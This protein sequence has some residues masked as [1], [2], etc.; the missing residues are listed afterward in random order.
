MAKHWTT[1]Q[2]IT[3]LR[4]YTYGFSI[5]MIAAYLGTTI[6]AVNSKLHR[7]RKQNPKLKLLWRRS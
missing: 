3:L 4:E 2:T 6:G 5:T 1:D 7:L